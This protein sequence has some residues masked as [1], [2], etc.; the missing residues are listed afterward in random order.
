[1]RIGLGTLQNGDG[2]PVFRHA[3]T[4]RN[5][6]TERRFFKAGGVCAVTLRRIA[7]CKSVTEK[8]WN[9]LRRESKLVRDATGPPSRLRRCGAASFAWLAEP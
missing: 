2:F 5:A 8:G 4:E 6:N 3:E 9:D 7:V 1:M